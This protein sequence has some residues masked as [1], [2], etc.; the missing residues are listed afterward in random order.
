M[1]VAEAAIAL[2]V[3]LDHVVFDLVR[4]RRLTGGFPLDA[5]PQKDAWLRAGALGEAGADLPEAGLL[6]DVLPHGAG[7]VAL[8]RDDEE[9]VPDTDCRGSR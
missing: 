8:G 6:R 9:A 2:T 5:L 7:H 1:D 3:G 4:P